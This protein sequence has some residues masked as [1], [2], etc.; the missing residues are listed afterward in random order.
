M[1][2]PA[3]LIDFEPFCNGSKNEQNCVYEQR[4]S[5]SIPPR[6]SHFSHRVNSILKDRMVS[7]HEE[8]AF[9]FFLELFHPLC[10]AHLARP[11]MML[12]ALQNFRNSNHVR[13]TITASGTI[14]AATMFEQPIQ[15]HAISE[16]F[17]GSS[18]F[19]T[20]LILCS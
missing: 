4:I 18:S 12:K 19:S 9:L 8:N 14:E 7:I 20:S 3:I 6:S 15:H 13:I 5:R 17:Y 2:R 11:V 10:C 16:Q 1:T